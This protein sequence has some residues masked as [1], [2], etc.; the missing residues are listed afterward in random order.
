MSNTTFYIVRH[1]ESE[2]NTLEMKGHVPDAR[3]VDSNLTKLGIQQAEAAAKMLG[4][5]H[6]DRAI[7]S[8]LL[9]AKKTAEI[10]LKDRDLPLETTKILRE[11]SRGKIVGDL[12][13]RM[14]KRSDNIFDEMEFMTPEEQQELNKKYGIELREEVTNRVLTFLR[15]VAT[16]N[17][18]QTTLIVCHGAIMR[19]LLMYLGFGKPEELPAGTVTN[20]SFFVLD[21]DGSQFILKQ[22][23]GIERR[24][25]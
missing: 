25:S 7:S 17:P 10:I 14:A 12:E 4:T 13:K 18:G 24:T 15:K 23:H 6:F 2:A 22:T 5:V 20:A 8:D 9:R 11:R 21:Y 3:P 1:G 19:G 16:T